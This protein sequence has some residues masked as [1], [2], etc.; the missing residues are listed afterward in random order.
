M[1]LFP[2]QQVHP[3]V[4][5]LNSDLDAQPD[6]ERLSNNNHVKTNRSG[7]GKRLKQMV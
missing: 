4:V 5:M 6:I 1:L 2:Q 3:A 7:H